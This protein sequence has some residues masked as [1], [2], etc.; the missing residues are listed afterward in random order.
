M[1]LHAT[2]DLKLKMTN[3]TGVILGTTGL[4]LQVIAIPENLVPVDEIYG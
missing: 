4:V 1:G 2:I 3:V